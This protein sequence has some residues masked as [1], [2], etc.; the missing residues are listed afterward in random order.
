MS[1][2]FLLHSKPKEEEEAELR[3]NYVKSEKKKQIWIMIF[4]QFLCHQVYLL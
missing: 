4:I 2:S 3:C 1:L